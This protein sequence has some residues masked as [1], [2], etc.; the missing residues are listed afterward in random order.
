[1]LV[2]PTLDPPA[3][4]PA[5]YLSAT[6]HALA[7]EE[8]VGR[9]PRRLLEPEHATWMRFRG[10]L[11]P[12]AFVELLLEDAAVSQPEPFDA[13]S[14]LG[15][16]APLEPV[17]E[18]LLADWLAM[19][20]GLSLDSPTRDYLDQQAQRLGLTARLAYSD[21]HRLQPHHR[22]LELPGT[23]GRLAAHVVQTQPGVFLKDVFTIACGSWQ[24]RALAGLVAVDLGVVGEVRLRLDPDLARI[25]AA[26]E[27]FSHVFGLRPDK[28][29]AFEREQLALW[30]PSA[31]IVLV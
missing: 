31:D 6:L 21:L 22:V 20:S 2:L 3:V 26:G 19:V 4:A 9:K 15:A 17:P 27:G 28:G 23:G 12:R 8:H 14:V 18:D 7:R 29:G 16:D 11:G 1:M 13:A 24:E 10:R 5:T 30:F 25:R